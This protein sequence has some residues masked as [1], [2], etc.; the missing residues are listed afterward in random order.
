M[1]TLARG[2][3]SR[4]SSGQNWLSVSRSQSLKI[5]LENKKMWVKLWG[6]EVTKQKQKKTHNSR[7]RIR[8]C[9]T[10]KHEVTNRPHHTAEAPG[11]LLFFSFWSHLH[12]SITLTA[13]HNALRYFTEQHFLIVNSWRHILTCHF[14][15]SDLRLFQ[16][17]EEAM[18]KPQPRLTSATGSSASK[19]PCLPC[20]LDVAS[21]VSR[22][23]FKKLASSLKMR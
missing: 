2:Q 19:N 18:A 22:P 5:H 3:L 7:P 15:C 6:E 12:S 9:C 20:C 4:E 14:L 16:D 1:W 8:K 10:Q 17:Q 21:L 11:V 13:W 23:S